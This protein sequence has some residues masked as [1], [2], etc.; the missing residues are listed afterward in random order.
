MD[1]L[2]AEVSCL[3]E[4]FVRTRLRNLR[5]SERESWRCLEH[6]EDGPQPDHP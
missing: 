5:R 3:L 2:L 6:Q 4:P 1:R